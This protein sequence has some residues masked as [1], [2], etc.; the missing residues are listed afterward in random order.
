MV[1]LNIVFPIVLFDEATNLDSEDTAELR[2]I[3]TKYLSSFVCPLS[4]FQS[5]PRFRKL[6]ERYQNL[7]PD[8]SLNSDNVRP[9]G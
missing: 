4:H 5:S 8:E 1:A 9:A 6:A 2:I 3:S 7:A